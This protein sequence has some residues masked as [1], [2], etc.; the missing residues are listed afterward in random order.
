MICQC[1]DSTTKAYRQGKDESSEELEA[2]MVKIS[3]CALERMDAL[4][5]ACAKKRE[6]WNRECNCPTESTRYRWRHRYFI[7]D[8]RTAMHM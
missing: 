6:R 3:L 5:S 8:G 7:T 4:C 1:P 2:E